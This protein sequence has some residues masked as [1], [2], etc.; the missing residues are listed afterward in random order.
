MKPLFTILFLSYCL[1]LFAQP[2]Q[3]FYGESGYDL[4]QQMVPSGDGNFYLLGSKKGLFKQKIWLSKTSPDGVVLWEKTYDLAA[5]VGEFGHGLDILSN[6]QL[7]IT[8][9]Q[10]A[11]DSQTD[12]FAIV[13]LADADGNQIW[14][15]RFDNTTALFSG[16][17]DGSGFLLIGWNEKTGTTNE[18]LLLKVNEDGVFQWKKIIQVSTQAYAKQIFAT[19]DGNFLVAGR[20]NNIGTGY[21]GVFFRKIEPDGTQ[22]W[23]KRFS[24][25]YSEDAF[26]SFA[27]DFRHEP[28]G[29][30]QIQDGSYWLVNPHGYYTV[31]IWLAHFSENGD[32]LEQRVY[33][34]P[35]IREF[36]YSLAKLPDGG[37]LIAGRTET[38]SNV[39]K[40]RHG[41]A[42]RISAGGSEQWRKYYG[43]ENETVR[44]FSGAVH[45]DGG[46]LL[47]GMSNAAEG[48]GGQDGWLVHIEENGNSFPFKVEGQVVIDLN[49]NCLADSGDVPAVGWF[50]KADDED[51]RQYLVT[52]ANGR[53]VH[54]T[55]WDSTKFSVSTS[56]TSGLWEICQT[57]IMALADASNPVDSITFVVQPN[58]GKCPYTEVSLTQ[59]DF[60]RCKGSSF[61]VSVKNRGL[62]M[63]EAQTLQLQLDNALT[64]IEASEPAFQNGQVIE[65][66]IPPIGGFSE[67]TIAVDVA[68]SCD[69]QLGSNHPVLATLS[70][71]ECQPIWDGPNFVAE[72]HCGGD[73]VVFEMKNIGSGGTDVSTTYRIL[74][75]DLIAVDGVSVQL[76]EGGQM[77]SVAFPADGRTWRIE[78]LQ[79]SGFPFAPKAIAF[80]EGCG[81]GN[82]GLHSVGFQD[83][84]PLDDAVPEK[85]YIYPSNTSGVPN[86]IAAAVQGFGFYNLIGSTA[87]IEF[88]ARA[89][90][91]FP[92]ISHRVD[93]L[94]TISPNLD[95]TTFEILAGNGPATFAVGEDGTIKATMEGLEIGP[96]EAAMLRFRLS[97][98][99]DTPPDLAASSLFIVEGNAFFDEKGPVLLSPGYVNYSETFPIEVD[100][101]NDYP[102]EA[103]L[104]G[105]RRHDFGTA[106]A[107]TADGA[108]LLGGETSSFSANSYRSG[109]LIKTD[110]SGK[111]QWMKTIRLDNGTC[112]IEGIIPLPDG[113]C[114]IAGDS[115]LSGHLPNY[116]Y[117]HYPYIARLDSLGELVWWKRK[118]PAGEGYSAWVNGLMTTHDG[119]FL[120]YGYT[121]NMNGQGTDEFYWKTD[122]TG[123]T[124]WVS[125]EQVTGSAFRPSKGAALSDGS[126]V[127]IG[128]NLS[129]DPAD[130][131]SYMQKLNADGEKLWGK[132]NSNLTEYWS[133]GI[134][135][136]ENGEFLVAGYSIVPIAPD[137]NAG[138]PTFMAFT[139]DGQLE[140]RKHSV[141][142]TLDVAFVYD[143]APAPQGGYYAT[144]RM[145]TDSF[146]FESDMFLLRLN[147]N[148]EMLWWNY[149]STNNTEWATAV[150]PINEKQVFLFGYNQPH[151][152]LYN[153]QSVL[154]LADS[155]GQLYV[156]TEETHAPLKRQTLVFPNPSFEKA[157]VILSPAPTQTV[158]WILANLNGQMVKKGNST[159]GFFEI[160][161]T[162][163]AN[164]MY[165]LGF[166]NRMYPVQKVFVLK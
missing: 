21:W 141:I 154:V 132:F 164:G 165:I 125:H 6:G 98:F 85:S 61:F 105:G 80:L 127:F 145:P 92:S 99:V 22:I 115:R 129:A 78:L 86:K 48:N 120:V 13:L 97:P 60:V 89:T 53:F 112:S 124:I 26:Y 64:F 158:Q 126:L 146:S 103:H 47:A 161:T 100:E 1:S 75:D 74:A 107:K 151:L 91:R 144:G 9:Q 37:W 42:M 160:P 40:I 140:W 139:A 5:N 133:G 66:D 16:V 111:A 63:S 148:A 153:L 119:Q 117:D 108:V 12:E 134:L 142:G 150:L 50:A 36:P 121:L 18:G 143:F 94:L 166:P 11:D 69:V 45:P 59:P 73:E 68:L 19:S 123:A 24:T 39:E 31:D 149:Y 87:P 17:P 46:F 67:K 114:I 54:H 128:S 135:P 147:E 28:L 152:P 102:P 156:E 93:F 44:L 30:I 57:E 23:E 96:G 62:G 3:Y 8:G 159:N 49:A 88:T 33:G 2:A 34:N 27:D 32:L 51:G 15:S 56:N 65:F 43:K 76:P 70:P 106:M 113:G 52:D 109:L 20:A 131:N 101:Y 84:F 104:F 90:N 58:D 116:A 29:M 83:A 95:L 137:D 79:P 118:R 110:L 155:S 4:F 35:D 157:Q 41:F 163:L 7:L 72:A 71:I 82:N 162:G 81:E 130:N 122:E 77:E 136:L 138:A 55:G 10:R 38:L 25:G 14:K